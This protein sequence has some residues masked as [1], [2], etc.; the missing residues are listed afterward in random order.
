MFRHVHIDPLDSH[1]VDPRQLGYLGSACAQQRG[2]FEHI[3]GGRVIKES[4][5]KTWRSLLAGVINAWQD[6]IKRL[7]SS[8]TDLL[9]LVVQQRQQRRRHRQIKLYQNVLQIGS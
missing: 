7:C 8:V 1:Q 3:N 2:V 9:P 5:T 4:M 6:A